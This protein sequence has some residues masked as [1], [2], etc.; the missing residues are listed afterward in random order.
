MRDL[1]HFYRICVLFGQP[2]G[3]WE[4]WICRFSVRSLQAFRMKPRSP[5]FCIMND[6]FGKREAQF[7]FSWRLH[8]PWRRH[9]YHNIWGKPLDLLRFHCR[10]YS[11]LVLT[12]KTKAQ[13]SV[14]GEFTLTIIYT[15]N[16]INPHAGQRLF[17]SRCNLEIIGNSYFLNNSLCVSLVCLL[18]CTNHGPNFSYVLLARCFFGSFAFQKI[19][20]PTFCE[21][22]PSLCFHS[23]MRWEV[24]VFSVPLARA[25]MASL[26]GTW[27]CLAACP[28]HRGFFH[29][30]PP[31]PRFFYLTRL[32]L[33]LHF[34]ELEMYV[35]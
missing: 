12:R 1:L 3:K 16:Q 8:W 2:D 30:Q 29:L 19:N 21:F 33:S 28:R 35:S 14:Q 25:S 26:L 20:S 11:C 13:K 32:P 24:I 31:P 22:L 15:L 27:Y 17:Y 34:G 18:Q 23:Q 10:H 7:T 9:Y 6:H 4:N 5:A